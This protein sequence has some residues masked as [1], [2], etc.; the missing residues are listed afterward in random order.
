MQQPPSLDEKFTLERGRVLL[1]GNEALVR[2]MLMQKARDRANGLH[3]AG[4]ASGYR[5]SPLGRLDREFEKAGH[6]LSRN[7]IVFRPGLNEDLAATA[8]WGTQQLGLFP[9]ARYDGVFGLWYGKGPGVDRSMD[10]IRHAQASGTAPNGGALLLVGDDHGAVSSTLP[11]Q[12]EHN[13][14][15]AMVPLLSAAGV[16]EFPAFG[17]LG[18][19]MSRFS[20][21]WVGFK[22]Q[23]D[24]VE[25]T[26]TVEVDPLQPEIVFPAGVAGAPSLGIRWPDGPAAQE[27]RLF[28]D[29]MAAVL[30][31]AR[32][33][34]LNRVTTGEG[35]A[36]VGV[37][38][39]GK[40]WL[41]LLGALA[42]LGIDE[43]RAEALGLRLYKIGLVWPLE[44]E[45]LE[46]FVD[47][48]ETVLVVEEKRPVIE[49]DI[50]AHLFNRPAD[51]RPRIV[52]KAGLDGAPLLPAWGEIDPAMIARALL[53]LL[54][55]AA[56][57]LAAR[58]AAVL[59]P[60]PTIPAPAA[61]ATREPYFC[62]GCPHSISTRVPEGSR[63]STGIGCHM[64]V[65]GV[66]ERATATFTQM[67]GE[68]VA[69]TGMAPFTDERHIFVNMGDG[70]YF[71]SGLLA[72]RASVAVRVNATYKILF[73][74]AV[75][76]TGGQ[77]HD[78]DLTVPDLVRQ[79]EAEGVARVE[80]V[81]EDPDRW[82]G[83]LPGVTLSHRDALDEVQ[84]RLREIPGVTAIVFDQVCAAEKRRR[85][86]RGQMESGPRR[87]FINELVCEG[88][89]DCS[90]V[91]NCIA[92]EPVETAFG[93]KRRIN[94]SSCNTDLSCIKGF[95]PS[96]VT[97]EGAVPRRGQV[98]LPDPAAL[99]AGLPE[100]ELPA[101]A[102]PWAMLLAG[103]GG[104]G[105][106]T[107]SAI[108]AQAAHLDGHCV[109]ALDQTGLAQKNGAVLSHLRLARDPGHL[110][111]IRI[112]RGEADALLGFDLVT[113]AGPV[114]LRTA[115]KERTRAVVDR[116]V[117]P[118]AAFVKDNAVDIRGAALASAIA[119]ATGEAPLAVDA[120]DLATRLLGD[121]IAA[122]MLVL[123]FAWQRGLVP[124]SL[125]ALDA[126][127]AL[128]GVAV[129]MN[130]AAFALGRLAA[131]DAGAPLLQG[132]PKGAAPDGSPAERLKRRVAFL[133]DYQDAAYA[134]RFEAL[135]ARA[136]AAEQ[137]LGPGFS[138]LA[139]AVCDNAFR[140]MAYKDEYEV[141][142]LYTLP[143][144]REALGD[145]F[146]GRPRLRFHL[147]PPLLARTD[148]RTGRPA[149]IAFGAWMLPVFRLLASLRTLRGTAF[150][151]FGRTQERRME[152]RLVEGYAG[153]VGEIADGL[154][155][156]N[157]AAA[158]RLAGWPSDIRGFGPVKLAAVERASLRRDELLGQWRQ[159]RADVAA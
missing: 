57:D 125:G 12:S 116:A 94:Q 153:L 43:R 54:G 29:K 141:A 156:D 129:A 124:C 27:R 157:H 35:R 113:A 108:L 82:L 139:E 76:M 122:N 79:L 47:G 68:G 81:A 145:A 109:Q 84:R 158:V 20:G 14:I 40:A 16:G 10:V 103:I 37:V 63:A 134:A 131:H 3:T 39:S 154:T 95:C 42:L 72:I 90:A 71:H 32:A 159:A 148:P 52:G 152:R 78:G 132:V 19:A 44:P 67:G 142:R 98:A 86:K 26:A 155:P 58:A 119:G 101:L 97:V 133:T 51:R 1:S 34:R 31:F 36:R 65:I 114:A 45:G 46:R 41:D 110:N 17:L 5:G 59:A 18:W 88:C 13:L 80:V 106:L 144:F 9:G 77:R 70:T 128:N 120:T 33:N 99:T 127:I 107:V 15:S 92:V 11:H 91:S 64:M 22:C 115:A 100:P 87:A 104:T 38:A 74:D 138:G 140:L 146:E 93:R 83:Q 4:F 135:V 23:T 137:R 48:L 96:F 50:K 28:E 53:R 126:A 66:P 49:T 21:S 69:W 147:A 149:K 102:E 117:A 151:L 8:V 112:G 30:A 143:S 56:D 121:A 150:D 123:G 25:S 61:G 55:P 111:A 130:R 85:R 89:G 73:N 2:M 75:A 6:L 7:D 136:K 118:T 60:E 62:A 24:I 105:V